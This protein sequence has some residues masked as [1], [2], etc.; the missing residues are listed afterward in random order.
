MDKTVRKAIFENFLSLASLQIIT[1]VIPFIIIPYLVRILGPE[2]YGLL[3]FA[4]ALMQYFIILIDYGF[5]LSATREISIHKADIDRVSRIFSAVLTIKLFLWALSLALLISLVIWV[6]QLREDR[7][8]YVLSFGSVLGSALFCGFFFLGMEKMK[9]LFYLNL[10]S[11]LSVAAIFVFVR[12]E[13]HLLRVPLIGSLGSVLIG[14]ASLWT[15]YQKFKVKFYPFDFQQIRHQLRGGWH[16]FVSQFAIAGYMNTRVFALG[17]LTNHT[18]TG[19][20]ALAE[21]LM[22]LILLFPLTTSIQVFYPRLSQIF[23]ENQ[24]DSVR[25]VKKLQRGTNLLYFFLLLLGFVFAPSIIKIFYGSPYPEAVLSLRILLVA[26]FLI[27]ANAYRLYFLMI[28]GRSLVFA[29]I[30]IRVTAFG[31]LLAILFTYWFSYWGTAV[32]IILTALLALAVTNKFP[33]HLEEDL[34]AKP[35]T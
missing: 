14:I 5:N 4:Q 22:N 31:T 20:Y 23:I 2:K 7:L 25:I 6:P 16:A 9:Y 35:A 15:V 12:S 24:P 32:S 34:D 1:F 28:S 30:H 10:L 33:P 19:Y 26:A 13:Q 3:A 21:K 29:K 27:A 18:L 17:L 11:L 8:F